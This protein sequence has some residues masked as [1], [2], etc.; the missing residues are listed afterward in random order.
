M[1]LH[2]GE[3]LLCVSPLT[4]HREHPGHVGRDPG[5]VVRVVVTF[6]SLQ[7]VER[8]MV[9][10]GVERDCPLQRLHRG[11]EHRLSHILGVQPG[12]RRVPPGGSVVGQVERQAGEE[13][14]ELP[15]EQRQMN[16]VFQALPGIENL[17]DLLPVVPH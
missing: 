6:G 13:V 3:R 8:S 5:T 14:G 9:L 15:A 10:S 1:A 17:L 12:Q 16:A 11:A 7:V 4:Q 2:H